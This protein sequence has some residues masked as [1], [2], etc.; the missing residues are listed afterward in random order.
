MKKKK[1]LKKFLPHLPPSPFSQHTHPLEFSKLEKGLSSKGLSKLNV[2]T[3]TVISVFWCCCLFTQYLHFFCPL[4]FFKV[5]PPAPKYLSAITIQSIQSEL[6]QAESSG[7]Q[8]LPV[9]KCM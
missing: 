6:H 8:K 1:I 4:D 7:H 9:V 5:P 2:I 3:L